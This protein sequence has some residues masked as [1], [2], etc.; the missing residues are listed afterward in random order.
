MENKDFNTKKT[1]YYNYDVKHILTRNVNDIKH[2]EDYKNV[3]LCVNIVNNE[4][5]YPFLQYLL[6][7][8]G[9]NELSIPKLPKYRLFN[10]ESLV[11]YSK[12]FLSGLLQI[13]NFDEFK[14]GIVFDGFYEY[15]YDL[16]LFFDVSKCNIFLD[17]IYISNPVRFALIDEII[18]QKNVCNI[19]IDENTIFFMI[20]NEKMCYLYD[21]KNE[22]YELPI[23]GYVGK[24]TENKMKFISMFGE[25]AKDK[26][27]L[28][29][30]YFY[31]TNFK[32]SILQCVKFS[33][34]EFNKGGIV[35]FA[36]FTGFIK[37][38]E[39]N[40]NS[41]NDESLIKQERL[42]DDTLDKKREILTL[43]ISD[44]DGIWAKTYDS[45]YLNELELDDGSILS[46]TP[47]LV[48]REYNQQLPLTYHYIDRTNI[49]SSYNISNKK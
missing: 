32:N 15:E 7:D 30:P 49:V 38:I 17:E 12:V 9:Y 28:L 35:R 22:P 5:K 13:T 2:V 40:Q 4:G 24:E 14:N 8:T 42:E 39:N 27:A 48:L 31:F 25:S 45:V 3:N 11:P 18:N 10:N 41:P 16:Y 21:E 20:N 46:D 26:T 19:P 34:T 47:M 44:H 43:R 29:G 23:V 1:S 6:S 37:Y 33:D 36:L